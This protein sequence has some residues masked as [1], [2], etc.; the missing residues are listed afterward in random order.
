MEAQ[1]LLN[2][3]SAFKVEEIKGRYLSYEMIVDYLKNLPAYFN[4][5]IEGT[6][7]LS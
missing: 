6:S 3:Y 4:L 5:K 2:N 7:F 1:Q